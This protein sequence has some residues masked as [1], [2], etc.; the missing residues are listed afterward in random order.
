M[1]QHETDAIR[2]ALRKGIAA[3]VY[4]VSK[5]DPDHIRDTRMVADAAL[6]ALETAGYKVV[7]AKSHDS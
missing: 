7:P 5:L 4:K 3:T 1:Q 6:Q 2:A